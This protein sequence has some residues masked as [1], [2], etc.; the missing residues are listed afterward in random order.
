MPKGV[1]DL[2]KLYFTHASFCIQIHNVLILCMNKGIALFLEKQTGEI[3]KVQ[4]RPYG[5]YTGHFL[6]LK[7]IINVTQPLRKCVKLQSLNEENEV[8]IL[9]LRNER[10]PDFCFNCGKI[11]H[12]HCE[13]LKDKESNSLKSPCRFRFVE[14]FKSSGDWAS[15]EVS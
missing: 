3:E 4:V 15:N 9:L 12:V 14:S 10:L 5:G 11:G 13:C 6:Q 2:A 7:V 1:R 8:I